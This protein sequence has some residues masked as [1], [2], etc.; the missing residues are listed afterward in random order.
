SGGGEREQ[1]DH[2]G[3]GE[4]GV[5]CLAGG[6]RQLRPRGRPQ[7]DGPRGEGDLDGCGPERRQGVPCGVA[8][9][10]LRPDRFRPRR[11]RLRPGLAS[12]RRDGSDLLESGGI[13]CDH[14]DGRIGGQLRLGLPERRPGHRS[15][16]PVD[17]LCVGTE[18]DLRIRPDRPRRQRDERV[19]L[20]LREFKLGGGRG[21][22]EQVDHQ[23]S[24][25]RGCDGLAGRQRQLRR[26]CG[27]QRDGRRDPGPV[28]RGCPE[29]DQGVPGRPA[30]PDLRLDRFRPRRERL[31]PDL[32]PDD[33]DH[34][35][36]RESGWILCDHGNGRFGGQL[37][38]GPPERRPGHRSGRPVDQL[39]VR[40]ERDL[41][42]G[43]DPPRW[44]RHERFGL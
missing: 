21:E 28:D 30:C 26:G 5:D 38:P 13:L 19:V 37:R 6:E 32:V 29:R 15:G 17:Q 7:R 42:G 23:G 22:R 25:C 16:R 33:F 10:D 1:V 11:E 14:G 34:R 9:P 35:D 39:R 8:E 27:A 44:Q 43:P 36:R 4:R 20:E 24:G 31:R 41:R 18:R 2:Q 3:C 12:H 40:V